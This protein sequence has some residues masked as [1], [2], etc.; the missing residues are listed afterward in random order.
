MP[1]AEATARITTDLN[2]LNEE[3]PGSGDSTPPR[4]TPHSGSAVKP[5]KQGTRRRGR[6]RPRPCG[7]GRSARRSRGSHRPSR[8]SGRDACRNPSGRDYEFAAR[9]ASDG[10]APATPGSVRRTRP[11]R[12]AGRNRPALLCGTR[13]TGRS[14]GISLSPSRTLLTTRSQMGDH[15]RSPAATLDL[16]SRRGSPDTPTPEPLSGTLQEM[17]VRLVANSQNRLFWRVGTGRASGV[18]RSLCEMEPGTRTGQRC[19]L[20]TPC[21]AWAFVLP[22]TGWP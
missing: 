21:W 14:A 12:I 3:L 13:A 5:G 18:L 17:I 7:P 16:V 11:E 1:D 15:R 2:R 9:Q 8:E 4:Q 22:R 20:G 6:R 10:P 19:R